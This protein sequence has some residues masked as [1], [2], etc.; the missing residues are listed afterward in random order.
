M[1]LLA[2]PAM[3]KAR[4]NQSFASG[5]I[6]A[7]GTLGILIPPSI[8]LIVYAAASG[9][10]SVRLYAGA[11]LP[12]LL[13]AGLYLLY[14]VGRSI[15]QPSVAPRP[16]DDEVPDIPV[17]KVVIMLLTSFFPLAVL[18]LSVLGAILF[19]LAT[20]SEAAA[21]GAGRLDAGHRLRALTWQRCAS[22]SISRFAR[23][24]WCAGC[25]SGRGR[26]RLCSLISAVSR[27]SRIS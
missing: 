27:S 25:S 8:M 10:S 11:M 7:G 20:P 4:Y 26:S 9:V 2:L 23:R 24:R 16:S 18:I 15:L 22:P 5:I 19:G 14:V 13:L 12:G 6:C 17:G 1:G 21:I 3:L